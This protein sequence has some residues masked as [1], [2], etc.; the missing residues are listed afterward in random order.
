MSVAKEQLEK[1]LAQAKKD[2]CNILTPAITTEGL[3]PLHAVTVEQL[4]LSPDPKQG[5]VYPH[6]KG[7]MII[8]KQGL[9]K[10][11][12]L[13]GIEMIKTVRTDNGSDRQYISYQAGGFIRKADGSVVMAVKTYGMDFEVI[14][15][16]VLEMYQDKMKKWCKDKGD[17]Q[18]PNNLHENQRQDY[19]N[20]KS[21]KEV[22]RRR[23]F[24]DQLCE[25]G[26][27]ARVKRDL[28]GLKTFYTP[29]ELKRPFVVVRVVL[30]PDYED[31]QIKMMLT[32]A[33]ISAQGQV[34]GIPGILPAPVAGDSTKLAGPAPQIAHDGSI[35]PDALPNGEVEDA[36]YTEAA[37]EASG[38]P[39]QADVARA[40]FEGAEPKSKIAILNKLITRKNYDKKNLK[41]PLADFKD[42]QLLSFYDALID[43]PDDDVPF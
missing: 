42:A 15:E 39:D 13:A 10:L 20:D 16:E 11:S 19:I 23:K 7:K 35:E 32:Q 38:A 14:E 8:H 40:D 26:A 28:L 37:A 18:W 5:D 2:K 21:R 33:A 43:M 24:K 3:T 4:E 22:R 41:V 34:F 17:N 12:N 1:A 30:K 31:P 36:D 25:S 27:Q 29:D 9:E 6:D